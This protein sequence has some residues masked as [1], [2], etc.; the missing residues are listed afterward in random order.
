[1]LAEENATESS[2][3]EGA[4]WLERFAFEH[5]NF[6]AGLA[7]LTETGDADWGLR[8]GTALFR[9]WEAREYLA[10]GRDRLGKLLRLEKAL[11]P[12]KARQRALFAAGV[13]AVEQGDYVPANALIRES[14]DIARQLTDKQGA[15]VA[16]NALAVVARDQGD[17]AVARSLLEES[18]VLWRDLSDQKA[19]ARCLNNLANIVKLQGDSA[20]ALSLHGVSFNLSGIGRLDRRRL[21]D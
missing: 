9:F 18:L 20:R 5:D 2:E 16:L 12:T 13:L 11:T 21:V 7:W 17:V 14:L 8:L 6:R 10:E 4:G 19:V 3:G 15:A 1:M